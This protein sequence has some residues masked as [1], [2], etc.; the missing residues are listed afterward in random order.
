MVKGG[1]GMCSVCPRGCG[2]GLTCVSFDVVEEDDLRQR[3]ST[4]FT[5]AERYA[6]ERERRHEALGAIVGGVGQGNGVKGYSADLANWE[7]NK[8]VY[9]MSPQKKWFHACNV[10]A[11]EA[12][13]LFT[14]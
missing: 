14:C 4:L 6:S 11:C 8:L 7:E 1:H 2:C 13:S 9:A 12:S 10:L 5:A 3:R